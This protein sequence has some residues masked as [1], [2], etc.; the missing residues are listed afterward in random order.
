MSA[1]LVFLRRTMQ[2]VQTMGGDVYFDINGKNV[3]KLA[4]TDCNVDLPEGTYRIRMYKSHN[5]GAMI[6]FADATVQIKDGEAILIRYN[7]P[8]TV[9]MPGHI[10][11]YEYTPETADA[12]AREA[13]VKIADAQAK[14]AQKQA[15]MRRGESSAVKVIVLIA[16]LSAVTIVLG[17][18]AY[19]AIFSSLLNF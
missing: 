16:V 14:N 19:W 4:L 10:M 12:A 9:N 18:V 13:A 6:G 11:V 8:D 17:S 7:T 15:E 3:G 1:R 5:Y 2:E